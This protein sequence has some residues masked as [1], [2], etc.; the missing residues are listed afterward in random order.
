MQESVPNSEFEMKADL[1]LLADGFCVASDAS[2]EKAFASNKDG[3][4]NVK[5]NHRM[6]DGL[7]PDL[8]QNKVFAAGDMRAASLWWCGQ[9]VRVVRRARGGM[10][11]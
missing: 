3:A 5:A 4:A 8:G 10:S 9:S 7:L 2:A 1:V 11:F 6:A